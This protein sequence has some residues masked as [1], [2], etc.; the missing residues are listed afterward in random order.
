MISRSSSRRILVEN[1]GIVA[2]AEGFVAGFKSIVQ[3]EVAATSSKNVA[4]GY[5]EAWGAGQALQELVL[6]S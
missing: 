2:A 4:T 6:S 1:S 3:E 5:Q